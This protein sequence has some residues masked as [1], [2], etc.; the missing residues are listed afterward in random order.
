MRTDTEVE[1]QEVLAAWM[2]GAL[3][4]VSQTSYSILSALKATDG[5]RTQTKHDFL[6]DSSNATCI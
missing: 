4:Y 3:K 1:G 5:G 2:K 6:C